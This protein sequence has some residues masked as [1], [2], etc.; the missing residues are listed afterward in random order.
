MRLKIYQQKLNDNIERAKSMVS[1]EVSLMFKDFYSYMHP[2]VNE[3]FKG[4]IFGMDIPGSVCYSVGKCGKHNSGA[5]VTTA[6]DA[7]RCMAIG[8]S[9]FYIP[10]DAEDNREGLCIS[11][12]YELASLL[13]EFEK[14][15]VYGLITSG[16]LNEKHPS[17]ERL[18][19][20]W[21]SLKDVI[22]S[23]S[24]GGSYWLDR[25]FSLPGFVRDV[26]IGEYMIFGTIPFVEDKGRFGECSVEIESEIVGVYPERSQFII[27]CGYSLAEPDK[28]VMNGMGAY[29]CDCSSEYS[30][31][32]KDDGVK[33]LH[34]GMKVSM[35]PNYK[36]LVKLRYA[37]RVIV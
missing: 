8:V 22:T 7:F 19:F 37:E 17:D 11:S 21:R 15:E 14:V 28:C 2:L 36:S 16:C 20:I 25:G 10:I 3:T 30:M 34:V 13:R 27:D 18:D 32:L 4:D 23:I 29:F 1:T 9:R 5:I 24:L 35:R 33:D 31:F 6:A 12:A 26:R